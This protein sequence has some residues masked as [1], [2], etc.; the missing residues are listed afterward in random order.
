MRYK[1]SM[2]APHLNIDLGERPDEPVELW[3]HAQWANVACGGHAGDE[4]S[5]AR[6][7]ELARIHGTQLGAHPSYEDRENFGRVSLSLSPGEVEDSVHRQCRALAE[8]AGRAG[9]RVVH[10]K[11]HGAL[12]HDATTSKALARAVIDG[13]RRAIQA[14][15]IVGPPGSLLLR[16]AREAGLAVAAEGFA[17]R[18]YLPDGSLVPRSQP[19]ALLTEPEQ[20]AEQ[21]RRLADSNRFQTLC[22]HSDT[23]NA[24]AIARAV[25][26]AILM[27]LEMLGDGA[28]RVVL[29][30]RSH[31]LKACERLRA[32]P[33]VV[34][35]LVTDRHAMVRFDPRRPPPDPRALL[36]SLPDEMDGD[37]REHVVRVS[38][39]GP[40]LDEVAEL[41]G[42]GRAEV[43]ERHFAQTYAV[44]LVGF[45]PGFGYLGPL[46]EVLAAA[47]R[48]SAPR[49]R[50]PALSVAIA[51]GRTA[52]YPFS[53][54][55]GWQILG[56]AVGFRPFDPD[57]GA[58]L[59]L[60]DRVRFEPS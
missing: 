60:G 39:D 28:W 17:D 45:L 29:P 33:H 53:S 52:I 21:A 26:R 49:P 46:D 2:S 5:V 6:A 55:G 15:T 27:K 4:A 35:A 19:G 3:A 13:A 58:I 1:A 10:V 41:C 43:V 47:P 56:T 38:Y 30:E 20:A 14:P 18:G 24:L 16:L 25:R 23:P 50:V 12:Y 31:R 34:D 7:C 11:P 44:D 54:P 57:K 40:D 22:V 9:V 48:R 51:S 36:A 32:L 42:I 59:R 8:A 37:I